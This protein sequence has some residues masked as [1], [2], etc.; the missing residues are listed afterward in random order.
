MSNYF[1]IY[2]RLF[3]FFQGF[4]RKTAGPDKQRI[5]RMPGLGSVVGDFPG[6]GKGVMVYP[7]LRNLH[8]VK[9]KR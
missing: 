7:E 1:F 9:Q 6:R 5:A 2:F 3:V 4:F 8:R